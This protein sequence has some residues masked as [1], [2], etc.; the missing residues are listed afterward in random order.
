MIAAATTRI[1]KSTSD[2]RTQGDK[3][4]APP[5]RLKRPKVIVYISAE[6]I[7]DALSYRA[8]FDGT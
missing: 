3:H 7:V 1:A 2:T 4:G 6:A 8:T 5:P